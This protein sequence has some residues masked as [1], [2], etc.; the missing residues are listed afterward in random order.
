MGSL[1]EREVGERRQKQ[2]ERIRG[3]PKVDFTKSLD[4]NVVQGKTALVTGGASGIGLGIVTSLAEK[5][6]RVAVLDLTDAAGAQV[7]QD[8]A[9]NV[10]FFQTDVTSWD[11][12][13]AAFKAILAWSGSRLDIAVLSAGV[14]SHNMKDLVLDQDPNADPVK[15]PSTVFD[16]NLVGTY[17]TMHL[18]LTYF[19]RFA[20]QGTSD[21]WKPQ[22]LFICSLAGYAEQ[23]L[24]VDYCASKHGVRG[25]WKAIRAHGFLFGGCQANLLA[26]TYI[27]NRQAASRPRGETSLVNDIK[28]GEV[29][30][31][32]AGAM[33]CIC[34]DAVH[35]EHWC[36]FSCIERVWFSA[37]TCTI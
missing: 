15:P 1:T 14:R 9:S 21:G 17:Y 13:L 12:Q 16:V 34:D 31:V 32:V 35:G 29:A 30:D 10:K 4:F 2:E 11:S 28:M 20:S 7:E 37:L 22:L 18:A 36:P 27:N 6:A 23:A 8:L 19:S 3:T 25:I 5:G 24:S 26:P 33:R